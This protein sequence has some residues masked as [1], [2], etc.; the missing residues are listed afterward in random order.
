MPDIII[1]YSGNIM[2]YDRGRWKDEIFFGSDLVQLT[3]GGTLIR[4]SPINMETDKFN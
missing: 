3:V 4:L 1:I 2:A